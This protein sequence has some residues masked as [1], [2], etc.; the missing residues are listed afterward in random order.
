M[1]SKPWPSAPSVSWSPPNGEA[2]QHDGHGDKFGGDQETDGADGH[3]FE[4]IN[5]LGDFHSTDLG[6]KCGAG[7]ADYN[8]GGDERAE[9][10]RHGDGNGGG[11]I[12]D[13]AKAAELIGSLQ[14]ED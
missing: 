9:F 13:G 10:A 11:D 12:A 5:F 14:S 8:D 2:R 7:T 6:G 1:L 3:G 4:S